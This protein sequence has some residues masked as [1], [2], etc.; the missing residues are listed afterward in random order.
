MLID[1]ELEIA[2]GKR[3]TVVIL[4]NLILI[5]V[6]DG[7]FRRCSLN[8]KILMAYHFG[9]TVSRCRLMQV[10]GEV[11]WEE[12]QVVEKRVREGTGSQSFWH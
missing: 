3:I 12:T 10:E 2:L 6:P 5:A 4:P 1:D 9:F 7:H 8:D 11:P